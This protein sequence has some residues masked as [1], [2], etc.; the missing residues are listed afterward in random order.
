MQ[1]N[2]HIIYLIEHIINFCD[3]IGMTN[4]LMTD[5][6]KQYDLIYLYV[7]LNRRIKLLEFYYYNNDNNNDKILKV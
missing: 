5:N 7:R 2:R 4:V 3:I 1:V 6:L